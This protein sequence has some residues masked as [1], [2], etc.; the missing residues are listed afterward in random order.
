[1]VQL[2]F[3]L[4][5]LSLSLFFLKKKRER[6]LGAELVRAGRQEK[7]LATGVEDLVFTKNHLPRSS[8]MSE[9]KK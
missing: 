2:F 8:D 5:A 1:M 3:S 9:R 6:D 7:P 4:V